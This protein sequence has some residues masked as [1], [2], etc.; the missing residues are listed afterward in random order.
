M[1]E[2]KERIGEVF[3]DIKNISGDM[4]EDVK[5]KAEDIID[6]T[7]VKIKE[8]KEK[9]KGMFPGNPEAPAN[10]DRDFLCPGNM[11]IFWLLSRLD[12]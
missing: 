10:D 9:L 3:G 1:S 12:K 2:Y 7:K 8:Y 11:Y 6:E 5:E 4:L